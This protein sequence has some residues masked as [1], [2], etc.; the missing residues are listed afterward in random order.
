MTIKEIERT[1]RKLRYLGTKLDEK[2][3]IGLKITFTTI[4]FIA[5]IFIKYGYIISPIITILF[6]ILYE[7]FTLDIP[8]E[9]RKYKLEKDS[10][11]FFPI[12][13]ISLKGGRN[14]KNAISISTNIIDNSISKEFKIVL[15]NVEIGRS[16]DDS[17]NEML[18]RIPSDIISN[19]IIS[20][21]ETNRLGNNLND[22]I[23]NQLEYL[24]KIENN[25]ILNSYRIIPLKISILSIITVLLLI[26]SL[27]VF[28]NIIK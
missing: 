24:K 12:L 5:L 27:F 18:K 23:N 20:I 4:I 8:L 19:M 14:I 25:K 3:Y 11:E 2:I 16:L 10:L 13:L 7:Y 1:K 6:Y 22:N 17:L 28:N 9:K 15:D 21:I 26:L